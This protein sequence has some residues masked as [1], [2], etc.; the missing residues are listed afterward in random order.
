MK[1]LCLLLLLF[2]S[3]VLA[4]QSLTFSLLD[5]EGETINVLV[6]NTVTDF[7]SN[8]S[9]SEIAL[10]LVFKKFDPFFVLDEAGL[11][12]ARNELAKS[13]YMKTYCGGVLGL[14]LMS[15]KD[16]SKPPLVQLVMMTLPFS[17]VKLT[18]PF[19]A[20]TGMTMSDSTAKY[21]SDR[22][23]GNVVCV[24]G[25]TLVNLV[26]GG[27]NYIVPYYY[28]SDDNILDITYTDDSY[29]QVF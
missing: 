9:D 29:L 10:G 6:P 28:S 14:N 11:L 12:K 19:R 24:H 22:Y 1:F 4:E 20:P 5:S 18:L 2:C 26:E 8:S 25:V 13:G 27:I 17:T 3:D 23:V 15:T 21:Y 7:Q 16:S